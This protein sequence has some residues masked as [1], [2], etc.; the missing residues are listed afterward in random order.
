MMYRF[1]LLLVLVLIVLYETSAFSNVQP[2]N[3]RATINTSTAHFMGKKAKPSMSD[4]RKKR[5]Q[6]RVS[7]DIETIRTIKN[8]ADSDRVQEPPPVQ[9]VEA[10]VV[11]EEKSE[12]ADE[13][14]QKAAS[15]LQSQR[16]VREGP[17]HLFAS[18]HPTI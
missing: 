6:R 13:I 2:F 14:D 10:E 9:T 1:H 4:R 17:W 7:P 11:S 16:K 5:A 15:L 3:V 12:Q 18:I 8:D